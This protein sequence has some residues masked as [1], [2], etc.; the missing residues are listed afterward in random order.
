M[1]F[2]RGQ[3]E[4]QCEFQDSHDCYAEKFELQHEFQDSHDCYTEKSCLKNQ[5]P[6]KIY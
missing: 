4:L 3:F 6:K 5:N 1:V 2:V